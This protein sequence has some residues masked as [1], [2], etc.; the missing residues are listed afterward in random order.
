MGGVRHPAPPSGA[1]GADRAVV[2]SRQ[3]ARAG[4]GR[5]RGRGNIYR[6]HVVPESRDRRGGSARRRLHAGTGSGAASWDVG[7]AGG[8]LFHRHVRGQVRRC[9]VL[10]G[11]RF[12]ESWTAEGDRTGRVDTQSIR[13]YS[14]AD[15]LLLLEGTGLASKH[16]EING[17]AFSLGDTDVAL[18]QTFE[19]SWEYLVRLEHEA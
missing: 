2:R 16:A 6:D 15:L 4:A 10:G 14:P 12:L 5:G 17:T 11:C 7:R 9:R 8:G 13:C 18:R 19:E 3:E 1:G